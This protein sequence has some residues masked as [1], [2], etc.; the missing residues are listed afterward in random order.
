MKLAQSG[1]HRKDLWENMSLT[2]KGVKFDQFFKFVNV[3]PSY[4]ANC[5]FWPKLLPDLFLPCRNTRPRVRAD[6]NCQISHQCLL[7]IFAIA[8]LPMKPSP[9]PGGGRGSSYG[10]GFE[11]ELYGVPTPGSAPAESHT[12]RHAHVAKMLRVVHA[13]VAR[14]IG[15]YLPLPKV[16]L[17]PGLHI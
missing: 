13:H 10:P 17:W 11:Y 6:T 4:D 7:Q 2:L 9:P 8:P 12:S 16:P 15:C 3:F 5:P 14:N 1:R